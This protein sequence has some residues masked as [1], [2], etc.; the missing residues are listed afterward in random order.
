MN[1]HT[2]S[3]NTRKIQTVSG[4]QV[5]AAYA[6]GTL[7]DHIANTLAVESTAL[8]QGLISCTTCLH[9]PCRDEVEGRGEGKGRREG[10]GGDS[11]RDGVLG[12]EGREGKGW[13]REERRGEKE[14]Q[15]A[16]GRRRAG[17][18][19][20]TLKLDHNYPFNTRSCPECCQ[21]CNSQPY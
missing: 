2:Y 5:A 20:Y 12:V 14:V 13:G 17:D 16:G 10:E 18:P 6:A 8:V 4:D 1:K 3:N 11:G 7:S 9:I 15:K 21:H 19:N